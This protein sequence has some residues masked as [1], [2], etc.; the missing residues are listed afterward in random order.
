MPHQ[1]FRPQKAMDSM[2]SMLT[3]IYKYKIRSGSEEAFTLFR[4]P[5]MTEERFEQDALWVLGNLPRL[6]SLMEDT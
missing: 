2:N 3:R 5:N 1:K 4:K 6:K